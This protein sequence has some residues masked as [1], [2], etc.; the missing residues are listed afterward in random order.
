[1]R[2]RRCARPARG[3]PA[4]RRAAASR[5]QSS[6]SAPARRGVAVVVP[7]DRRRLEL[8]RELL[9]REHAPGV[10]DRRVP[11]AALLAP[12]A[13]RTSRGMSSRHAGRRASASSAAVRV[14]VGGDHQPP[15][16]VGALGREAHGRALEVEP[17]A[18]DLLGL[19][20]R[21]RRVAAASAGARGRRTSRSPPR[22]A[23]GSARSR[24]CRASSA[25][26]AAV[27][28]ERFHR[29]DLA[30]REVGRRQRASTRTTRPSTKPASAAHIRSR[31]LRDR[32]AGL[33]G[34]RST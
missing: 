7:V 13:P 26:R 21:A 23:T 34:D 25:R 31:A 33:V 18:Q 16:R 22:S 24:C 32:A 11:V 12:E 2:E 9:H 17:R 10:G 28:R 19:R 15:Q 14:L 4:C 30:D 1:M 8:R 6:F 20:Q 29:R 3:N 27:A 5:N